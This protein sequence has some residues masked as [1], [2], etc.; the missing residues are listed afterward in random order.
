MTSSNNET[1]QSVVFVNSQIT[2]YQAIVAA[3]NPGVTVI[4]YDGTQ[5]GLAQIAA[6]SAGHLTISPPSTLFPMARRMRCRLV[7]MC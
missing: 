1:P 3:I 5:D 2:D 7:P 4:V 6:G